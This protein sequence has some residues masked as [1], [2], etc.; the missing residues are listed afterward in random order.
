MKPLAMHVRKWLSIL[1]S[2]DADFHYISSVGW[3]QVGSSQVL[4][5]RTELQK[6]IKTTSISG[7]VT[8]R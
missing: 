5:V 8:L 2:T 6:G 7:F 3:V 1:E 4:A